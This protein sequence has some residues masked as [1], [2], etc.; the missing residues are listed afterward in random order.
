MH[1]VCAGREISAGSRRL[2]LLRTLGSLATSN[3]IPT[4][5]TT[6]P[7]LQALQSFTPLTS[8]DTKSL[9]ERNHASFGDEKPWRI[10]PGP[11][12]YP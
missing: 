1:S 5:Q 6:T 11:G 4:L 7:Q 2:I 9:S 3:F 12:C 8:L 10:Q